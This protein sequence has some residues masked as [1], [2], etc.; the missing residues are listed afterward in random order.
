MLEIQATRDRAAERTRPRPGNRSPNWTRALAG[1]SAEADQRAP[2]R[3]ENPCRT[4]SFRCPD[5][6]RRRGTRPASG[7]R[8]GRP[9]RRPTGWTGSGRRPRPR[10]E[11][12]RSAL[13]DLEDRLFAVES[14]E[15]PE[16][17]DPDGPRRARRADRARPAA[18]G[19]GRLVQRTA[20]ERAQGDGR[21]RRGAAA[22]RPARS[23]S[24]GRGWPPP[25]RAARAELGGRDQGGRASAGGSRERLE[26]S[27]AARGASSGTGRS[28][29]GPTRKRRWP[30]PAPGRRNCRPVG[31]G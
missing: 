14:E 4:A 2:G 5:V 25:R 12:H 1:A 24:T 28:R 18:R 13:A 27:L 7:R 23:G 30:R 3:G 19:G 16:E 8:P 15:P 17:V 29:G 22:R 6:R 20:E 26:I 21:E 10:R 9:Q 31:R 11:Q